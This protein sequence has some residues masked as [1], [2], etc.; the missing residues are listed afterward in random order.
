MNKDLPIEA[1]K[2]IAEEYDLEQVILLCRDMKDN[3][4]HLVTYGT[5]KTDSTFAALDGEKLKR[6]LD[7]VPSS[8]EDAIAAA[9]RLGIEK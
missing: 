3:T 1:A 6:V 8:F 2:N 9:E 4:V 5:T 7:A